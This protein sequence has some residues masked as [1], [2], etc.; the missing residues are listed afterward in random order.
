MTAHQTWSLEKRILRGWTCDAADGER[1]AAGL[2]DKRHDAT[3]RPGYTTFKALLLAALFLA[4]SLL[5]PWFPA[6]AGNGVPMKAAGFLYVSVPLHAT[7][8]RFEES[9]INF[10][11]VGAGVKI[12]SLEMAQH[13]DQPRVVSGLDGQED[14]RRQ[15]AALQAAPMKTGFRKTDRVGRKR[16]PRRQQTR[17]RSAKTRYLALLEAYRREPSS[18]RKRALYP[19]LIAAYEAA[20]SARRQR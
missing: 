17:V 12:L 16:L 7:E 3:Y 10:D 4:V 6:R 14:W 8:A 2:H 20:L 15:R 13:S 5:F 19:G 18:A 1:S 9:T 11:F